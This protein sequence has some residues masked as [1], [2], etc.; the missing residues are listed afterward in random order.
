MTR[1]NQLIIHG[2]K[3]RGIVIKRNQDLDRDQ[4]QEKIIIEKKKIG[5]VIKKIKFNQEVDQKKGGINLIV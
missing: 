2:K 1:K 4:D 5:E 3:N